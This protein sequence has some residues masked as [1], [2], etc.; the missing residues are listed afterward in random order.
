MSSPQQKTNANPY[1]KQE[2]PPR[3][4]DLA[5][6]ADTFDDGISAISAHTLEEL[7]RQNQLKNPHTLASVK[8]DLTQDEGLD[9]I[10]R[11]ISKGSSTLFPGLE[12]E[13]RD[14]IDAA[15]SP[16]H[17]NRSSWGSKGAGRNR[18]F[19]TTS[20]QSTDFEKMFTQN[21]EE[22]WKDTVQRDEIGSNVKKG[23]VRQ[24][25]MMMKERYRSRSGDSVS[26]D[27]TVVNVASISIALLLIIFHSPVLRTCLR[28]STTQP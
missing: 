10:D 24:L 21:E 18:S 14:C 3:I 4:A 7:E 23:S 20:T 28:S 25:Q 13:E 2:V 12:E 6:G 5:S 11:T 17:L 1:L 8:S 15:T 19:Q 16:F 9:K 22:Y 27:C 26:F